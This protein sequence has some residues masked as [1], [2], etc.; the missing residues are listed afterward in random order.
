MATVVSKTIIAA[1]GGDY[2]SL[3]TWAASVSARGNN[4][5]TRDVIEEALVYDNVGTATLTATTDATRFIRI[6]AADGHGHSG[7]WVDGK[8]TIIGWY[9]PAYTKLIGLQITK[10]ITANSQWVVTDDIANEVVLQRC[11]IKPT[12]IGSYTGIGGVGCG[13]NTPFTL[14]SCI[15]YGFNTTSSLGVS[16]RGYGTVNRYFYNNTFYNCAIGIKRSSGCP[17]VA[18]NNLTQGC[19]DGFNGTF[20]TGSTNNCSDVSGDAPGTSTVT[21]TVTFVDAANGDFHLAASD[22]I[23]RGAGANLSADAA[24][25]V[26]LDIDG[27]T[28]T[29]WSIGADSIYVSASL[30]TLPIDLSWKISTS[31]TFNT[32]WA[33]SNSKYFPCSWAILKKVENGLSWAT[34]TR[35]SIA[36]AWRTLASYKT[37]SYWRVLNRADKDSS[38]TILILT[39]LQSSWGILSK[40]DRVFSWRTKTKTSREVYYNI[41]SS[42]MSSFESLWRIQGKQSFQSDWKIQNLNEVH[43]SWLTLTRINTAS[44]WKMVGLNSVNSSWAVHA[45]VDLRSTWGIVS[46][47]ILLTPEERVLSIL[48][49]QRMIKVL[50]EI[51]GVTFALDNRRIASVFE[52]RTLTI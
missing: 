25:P 30:K 36:S 10:T 50:G 15:F 37:E 19:A 46:D 48:A 32:A 45:K 6:K 41:L 51:R 22:T 28:I 47:L 20:A 8:A 49:D 24:Y 33:L 52:S 13:L 9:P 1:G 18:K 44:Y 26:L 38:W 5:V 2:T 17:I 14:D 23:A 21:G 43:S 16:S 35:A 42:N 4:L 7:K 27:Q 39:P 40:S 34:I 12:S 29:T 11:I 31:K 3:S